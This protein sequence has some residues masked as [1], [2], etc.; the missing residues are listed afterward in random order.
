MPLEVTLNASES[1]SQDTIVSL[2]WDCEGDGE[3]E[4]ESSWAIQSERTHVCT[5]AS[6]GLFTPTVRLQSEA[7]SQ[8][9]FE[10][11]LEI[12]ESLSF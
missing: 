4:A 5:Y 3:F 10:I 9:A 2:Q 1:S 8:S 12:L 11:I 6:D 7:V